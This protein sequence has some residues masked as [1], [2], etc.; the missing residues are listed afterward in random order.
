MVPTTGADGVAGCALISTLIDATEVQPSELV[1][2]KV[3]E[4]AAR[5]VTVVLAVEPVIEP[6]FIVHDPAG[7]PLNTTLPVDTEHVGWVIVPTVGAA[8]AA[9][10][11]KVY[12]AVAAAHGAPNG[13]L[14]VTVINTILP[15]SPAAGV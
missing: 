6:G 5:P 3:Y 9:L 10:T 4:P 14:V 11:V 12:V 7:K 13:L 15:A 1:T 2:V 8:G